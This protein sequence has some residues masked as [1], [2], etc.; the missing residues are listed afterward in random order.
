MYNKAS[1]PYFILFVSAASVCLLSCTIAIMADTTP[2][3]QASIITLYFHSQKSSREIASI[4]SVSLSIVS[5]ILRSFKETGSATPKQEE[6]CGRKSKTS[7]RDDKILHRLSVIDPGKTSGDLKRDMMAY[8][9]HIGS[10]S[11]FYWTEKST[12]IVREC[13]V[14]LRSSSQQPPVIYVKCDR[15]QRRIEPVT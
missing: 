6:K 14:S 7:P 3:K 15:L 11:K 8:G 10:T 12:V 5:K 2:R 4:M 13:E 1:L 9:V